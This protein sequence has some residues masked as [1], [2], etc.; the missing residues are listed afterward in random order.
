MRIVYYNEG[1]S[2][3]LYCKVCARMP[4][5]LIN[6]AIERT[7]EKIKD[8]KLDKSDIKSRAKVFKSF[9]QDLA[10]D[11]GINLD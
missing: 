2:M 10:L 1:R 5:K 11:S 8:E 7:K 4:I 6:K 3:S 9:I